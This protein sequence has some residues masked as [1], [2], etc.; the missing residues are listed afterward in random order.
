M[1]HTPAHDAL[2]PPAQTDAAAPEQAVL[3]MKGICKRF[4]GVTALDQVSVFAHAHEVHALMGENGAGK[5][6]LM[7]IL[8]GVYR[9]DAG[10]IVLDGRTVSPSDPRA[11]QA[12]GIAII[13]QELNQ[14]PEL[15]VAENF[16]LGRELRRAPGV[17]DLSLMNAQTTTWLSQLGLAIIYISH[18]M[19][20]IFRI[21]DRITVLRDGRLVGSAPASKLDRGSLIRW[22]VGRELQD[23]FPTRSTKAGREILALHALSVCGGPGRQSLHDIHLRV[24]AGEVVG[25]AGLLGAGRTEVLEAIFGVPA[26]TEVRGDIFLD[27]VATRFTSPRAAIRQGIGFVTEDRKQQSL[28]LV[29][30]VAENAGLASLRRY[31]PRGMLQLGVEARDIAAQFRA[32]RVKTPSLQTSASALSGGNQQKV[33]LAKWLLTRPRLVLLDEPTQGIDVG[34]KAEIYALIDQLAKSGTAVLM[35]SSEMPELL[36]LCDRIHVLCEGRLTGT[37][38]HHEATQERILDLATRFASSPSSSSSSSSPRH[39]TTP[40]CAAAHANAPRATAPL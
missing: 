11:A 26:R 15:S 14:V 17:M 21:S 5:S 9:A 25:L 24:R 22:M 7:K 13:H 40:P 31:A 6:T 20:E 30:S 35:A 29:R 36:A 18:R 8:S 23:L 10:A 33:V 27:G 19:D 32:L 2:R 38:E 28:V 37:L 34:A 4:A 12:L 16:F 1:S 3:Q 39:P